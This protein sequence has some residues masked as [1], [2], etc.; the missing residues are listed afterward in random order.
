MVLDIAQ[1]CGVPVRGVDVD[2]SGADLDLVRKW[3]TPDGG[4]PLLVRPDG[5]RLAG[6][7]SIVPTRVA[8]FLQGR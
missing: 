5:A 1:K 3:I 2:H 6:A 4:R 8:L 7:E